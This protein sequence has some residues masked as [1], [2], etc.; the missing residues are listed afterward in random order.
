MITGLNK[1][2]TSLK[3]LKYV[4]EWRKKNRD[5][6]NISRKKGYEKHK[7][8]INF[9]RRIKE[10]LRYKKD[11]NFKLKTKIRTRINRILRKHKKFI[12]WKILLGCSIDFLKQYLESRF[13]KGMNWENFN[14]YGWHIDHILPCYSFDLNKKSEQQKCFHYTNIQPLWREEHFKKWRYFIITK[15]EEHD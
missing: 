15:G 13:K 5:K 9:K 8:K 14:L 11:I 2:K 7:N 1:M 12:S 4:S 10:K 3:R 6:V